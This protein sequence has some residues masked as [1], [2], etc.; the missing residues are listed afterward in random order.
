[1]S[2]YSTPFRLTFFLCLLGLACFPTIRTIFAQ[3]GTGTFGTILGVVTD[4]TGAVVPRATASVTNEKTGIERTAET[5]EQ[6]VYRV[7]ALLPGIY[8]VQVDANGFKRGQQKGVELRVNESLRA[9]VTLQVGDLSQTVEVEAETPLLQTENATVGHVV[10]NREAIELPLNGRDFTQLT[11]LI[12]GAS[13]GFQGGSGLVIGGNNVAV[14]GNRSDSNNYTLDGVDNNENFFKFHGMKPSIDAIE[15]FKIQ[16][17]ITSAQFGN[18]AGANINVATKSGT[19]ELHGTLFEFFRN[20]VLDS[21]DY[22]NDRRPSFRFN[23]FG[24]TVGGPFTIP[25]VYNGKGKTFWFFD[26]EGLRRSLGS[27]ILDIVPTPEMLA[28]DLSRD[29]LGNPAPPI[30]DPATG[31]V[32][33]GVIV[34]DPF[35]GNI[36]PPSRLDPVATEY[37]RHQYPAPNRPGQIFNFVNSLPERMTT[38]Q[39]TIRLDHKFSNNTNLFGRFSLSDLRVQYPG[40]LPTFTPSIECIS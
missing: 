1:M 8:T 4:E 28:G 19:N 14:S 21:R 33:D 9:D 25:R 26:Y 7:L 31:R 5:N 13:P 20:D 15:E 39:F 27:T 3:T 23:N 10:N 34:R 24:G 40:F 36:I 22:F 18:A 17:N 29:L 35:P 38:D 30:F 37:A 2:K 16:T 6:G 32:V 11:L 12:P